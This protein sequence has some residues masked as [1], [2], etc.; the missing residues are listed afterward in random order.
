[1]TGYRRT[2]DRQ[3]PLPGVGGS[4]RFGRRA[5]VRRD[6][7]PTAV[8]G[9]LPLAFQTIVDPDDVLLHIDIPGE[10]PVPKERARFG[11]RLAG[12]GMVV[13][14]QVQSGDVKIIRSVY[15]P[16]QTKAAEEALR[17]VFRAHRRTQDPVPAPVGV[18]AFFK[19]TGARAD[20][21]NLFKL[22]GDAMNG[23]IVADDQQITEHHVHV[24]RH[25][26]VPGIDLLVYRT[27]RR[28]PTAR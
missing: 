8:P 26:T 17:W 2:R 10:I 16:E 27:G 12:T 13:K 25:A 23:V 1:M 21:D 15:T 20:G 18:L 19:T 14:G 24:L 3:D 11:A 4:A 7:P 22:I 5:A 28:R 6:S 9:T